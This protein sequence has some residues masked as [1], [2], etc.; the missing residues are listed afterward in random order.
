MTKGY[1]YRECT[2]LPAIEIGEEFVTPFQTSL[3]IAD[4]DEGISST[5]RLLGESEHT[6]Y[7]KYSVRHETIRNMT[8]RFSNI[9]RPNVIQLVEFNLFRSKNNQK[10]FLDTKRRYANELLKR[11]SEVSSDIKYNEQFVNLSDMN[12]AMEMDVVGGHFKNLKLANV[13]SAS[14][15]GPTITESEEWDRFDKSGDMAMIDLVFTHNHVQYRISI[16]ENAGTVI[17]PTVS[18]RVEIGIVSSISELI[19]PFISANP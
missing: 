10:I 12:K 18:E 13:K 8:V 7:L 19:Q 15:R 17:Y 4:V 5:I 2:S 9:V 16:T 14:V 11:L 6:D 3:L 1:Q